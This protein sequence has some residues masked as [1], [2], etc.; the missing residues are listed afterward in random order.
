MP[1][2]FDG[3]GDVLAVLDKLLRGAGKAHAL[4]RAGN[5]DVAWIE[6][7]EL[8]AELYELSY[9]KDEVIGIIALPFLT[10][11]GSGENCPGPR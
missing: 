9:G 6:W 10:P 11:Y 3:D 2:A 7:V 8:L 4:W 1:Q 5:D